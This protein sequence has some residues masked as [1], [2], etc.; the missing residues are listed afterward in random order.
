MNKI[1]KYWK[2]CRHH[3]IHL[4]LGKNHR[5]MMIRF[6]PGSGNILCFHEKKN[7]LSNN[8]FS[9]ENHNQ[10]HGDETKNNR[11]FNLISI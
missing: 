11:E 9:R 6:L 7:K 8:F 10:L 3:Q 4:H 2:Y 5:M 1:Q